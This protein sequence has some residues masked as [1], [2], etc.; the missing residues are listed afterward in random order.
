MLIEKAK[1]GHPA[2]LKFC[3]DR[4]LP[5]RRE[6]PIHLELPPIRCAEDIVAGYQAISAGVGAGQITPAEGAVLADIL[7]NQSRAYELVTM[8][9]RLRELESFYHEARDYRSQ[10][11]SIVETLGRRSDS[12]M[13]KASWLKA[14]T[15]AG[16]GPADV[17]SPQAVADSQKNR[18]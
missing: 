16:H 10:L 15:P 11:D 13:G 4:I 14:E 17:E 1:K 3:A 7:S 2:L 6:G 12:E 8:D 18:R 9:Q 5:V